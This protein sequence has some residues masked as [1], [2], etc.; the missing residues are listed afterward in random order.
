MPSG[1]EPRTEFSNVHV[2]DE[3]ALPPDVLEASRCKRFDGVEFR[4]VCQWTASECHGRWCHPG[5]AL[6]FQRAFRGSHQHSKPKKEVKQWSRAVRGGVCR[7]AELRFVGLTLGRRD[8]REDESEPLKS[9]RTC[10]Y[11]YSGNRC[12]ARDQKPPLLFSL[13][14]PSVRPSIGLLGDIY[15]Y[16]R[17]VACSSISDPLAAKDQT[18]T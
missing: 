2:G 1:V 9:S 7:R 12:A 13:M 8:A 5:V 14:R 6:T 11:C 16:V 17:G 15:I 10:V 3:P 18:R 4:A